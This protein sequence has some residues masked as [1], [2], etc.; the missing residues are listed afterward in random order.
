MR[1]LYC[2]SCGSGTPYSLEKPNFCGKCGLSFS[3][4]GSTAADERHQCC[5]KGHKGAP[6][7]R[8]VPHKKEEIA[9]EE[10]YGDDVMV[11]PQIDGLD[12]D[13]ELPRANTGTKLEHLMGTSDGGAQ[14]PPFATEHLS[15]A[16]V[17]NDLNREGGTLR[18]S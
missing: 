10:G 4:L 3:A 13:I 18:E 5:P 17:L 2:Q 1:K 12:I 16:Q 14:D 7:V 6:G 11:V 8:G 15:E 9:Q